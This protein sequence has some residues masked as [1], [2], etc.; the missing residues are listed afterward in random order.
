MIPSSLDGV[1]PKWIRFTK[2]HPDYGL[3][4]QTG[5]LLKLECLVEGS[6]PPTIVWFKDGDILI[7][8]NL[9]DDRSQT[10]LL[11]PNL[12][13]DDSGLYKCK[14]RN[15]WGE[16]NSTFPV[17]VHEKVG[18]P[19]MLDG[20]GT[21]NV[22]AEYGQSIL[23]ACQV[24]S[25]GP[26]Q[27]QW[28]KQL[29]KHQEP[30]NKNKTIVVFDYV[31]EILHPQSKT[32]SSG[33]YYNST[34][35]VE[36]TMP[37]SKGRYICLVNNQVGHTH[38]E[39]FLHINRPAPGK[40]GGAQDSN[41]TSKAEPNPFP[42]SFIIIVPIL[43]VI[44]VFLLFVSVFILRK[45]TH[46]N[47]RNKTSPHMGK[48][49]LSSNEEWFSSN[50]GSTMWKKTSS[51]D[52]SSEK[53]VEVTNKANQTPVHWAYGDVYIH[54]HTTP[55]ILYPSNTSTEQRQHSPLLNGGY[56]IPKGNEKGSNSLA[57]TSI[58]SKRFLDLRE[59]SYPEYYAVVTAGST[60]LYARPPSDHFYFKISDGKTEFI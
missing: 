40:E 42:L 46:P 3:H 57:S 9:Q 39:I 37:Y 36:S 17:K 8:P 27:I 49:N 59:P 45:H 18:P 4:F 30:K 38:K 54:H 53:W 50:P 60:E 32:T 56:S 41:W 20:I 58:E 47:G 11:I 29:H 2:Y 33:G 35:L 10:A 16:V 24:Q 13:I 28:L 51:S 6:P 7:T 23:F 14:A 12:Q 26:T 21:S 44:I 48:I 1:P 34:L 19:H 43:S 52:S 15:A 55:D 31:F 5:E 25:L 22:T